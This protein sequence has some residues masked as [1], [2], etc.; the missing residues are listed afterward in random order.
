ML[1]PLPHKN[2][3]EYAL[4]EAEGKRLIDREG[5][6][7]AVLEEHVDRAEYFDVEAEERPAGRVP[8]VASPPSPALLGQRGGPE[9]LHRD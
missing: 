3:D 4:T 6:V 1:K 8:R 5:A 7:E 9:G 2:E